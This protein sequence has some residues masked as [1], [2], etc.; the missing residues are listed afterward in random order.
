MARRTRPADDAPVAEPLFETPGRQPNILSD[1]PV[2]MIDEV[3]GHNPR[4]D[5]GDHDGSFAALVESIRRE[6]ILQPLVICDYPGNPDRWALI[7]GRPPLSPRC[8]ELLARIAAH[9][10]QSPADYLLAML[11]A[12]AEALGLVSGQEGQVA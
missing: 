8:A 11:T 5:Y 1:I 6:G 10:S 7:A 3:P 2:S 4:Q 12:R 9:Y